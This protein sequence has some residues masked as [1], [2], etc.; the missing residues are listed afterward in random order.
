MTEENNQLNTNKL[1]FVLDGE[2]QIVFNTDSRF[3]AIL[4]SNPLIIDVTGNDAVYGGWTYN[5]EDGTFSN[6]LD[7]SQLPPVQGSTE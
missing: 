6:P 3:A 5:A 7:I 4:L 1:A 2:C